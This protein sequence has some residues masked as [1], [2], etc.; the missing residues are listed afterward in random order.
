MS[1]ASSSQGN[2]V[3]GISTALL[4]SSTT[5]F[6]TATRL[7]PLSSMSKSSTAAPGTPLGGAL[8]AV[9]LVSPAG[10]LLFHHVCVVLDIGLI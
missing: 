10:G 1:Q 6:S 5:T 7:L 9:F 8:R 3:A 4:Y 2:P